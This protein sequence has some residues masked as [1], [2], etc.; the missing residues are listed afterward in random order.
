MAKIKDITDLREKAR[1][2]RKGIIEI[3]HACGRSAHPGPALSCADI[4]AALYY[5]FMNV[6]PKNPDKEDRDRFIL[7]KG[8]ACPVL[9]SV[10][11]EKGYFPKEYFPTLRHL[12]SKLQGHPV[13]GK[14]PG[15]DMTSGS[16]GNGLGIGLGMAYYL[17]NSGK[18]SKVFVMLGD[19]EMNEGTLWEAINIA[20]ALKMDNLIAIVDQ[21]YFQSCGST[22]DIC[23]MNNMAER[24]HA[25]GWN[26]LEINGHDM[27][28]CVSKLEM[29]VNH[30]GTPTVIIAQTIKGKGV[31]FMEHDNSWHQKVI[32]DEQ[33]EIAIKEL[34][35]V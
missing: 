30:H 19:G 34:E 35:E 7:S 25:F 21:N 20:P 24:W 16:L 17:K 1:L 28:E 12:D 27:E 31:S 11:A 18:K 22:Q 15:V 32:N 26:V 14:T 2:V 9:Y 6:D 29:A 8:H 33:Y 3:S 13:Y 5:G 23:P 10:L 4:V